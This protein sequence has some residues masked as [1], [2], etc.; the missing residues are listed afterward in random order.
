MIRSTKKRGKNMN[1][2]QK[3]IVSVVGIFIVLLALVGI[4]YGKGQ[5]V[6]TGDNGVIFKCFYGKYWFIRLLV[7]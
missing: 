6:V 1:R 7:Y 5:F 4:T 2:S 3:I